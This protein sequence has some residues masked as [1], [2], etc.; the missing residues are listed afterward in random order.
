MQQVCFSLMLCPSLAPQLVSFQ[1][2]E[3]RAGGRMLTARLTNPLLDACIWKEFLVPKPD[4]HLRRSS[5]QSADI[6]AQM[7]NSSS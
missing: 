4:A 6:D 1:A 5:A 3:M 7:G 2:A